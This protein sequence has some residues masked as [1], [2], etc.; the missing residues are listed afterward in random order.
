MDPWDPAMRPARAAP[1]WLLPLGASLLVAAIGGVLWLR[2][3]GASPLGAS[4]SKSNSHP[5]PKPIPMVSR[6]G[7]SP[8]AM[9]SRIARA[10]TGISEPRSA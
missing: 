6:G 8:M 9:R 7:I 4:S 5:P 2:L 1:R 3:P 10:S